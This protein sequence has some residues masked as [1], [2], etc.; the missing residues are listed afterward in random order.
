[1][2]VTVV[3]VMKDIKSQPATKSPDGVAALTPRRTIP[4]T[5]RAALTPREFASFF[6]K[7][8]SWGY[9][10]IYD[11]SVKVIM[12][13]RS[14]LIPSSEVHRLLNEAAPYQGRE[15]QSKN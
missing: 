1:M 5:D 7:S 13:S 3:G 2:R 8:Q 14:L 4:L 15:F 12:P 6:G 9:R 11:G 10:R